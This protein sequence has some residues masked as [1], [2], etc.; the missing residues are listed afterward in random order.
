MLRAVI[1]ALLAV[2]TTSVVPGAAANAPIELLGKRIAP[3]STAKRHMPLGESYAGEVLT[4]PV[5]RRRAHPRSR[6]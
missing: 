2:T 3:G 4:T 5:P 1:A 6:E